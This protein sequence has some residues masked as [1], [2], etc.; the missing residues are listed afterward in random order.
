LTKRAGIPGFGIPGLETLFLSWNL[1]NH[2]N[3]V[4]ISAVWKDWSYIRLPYEGPR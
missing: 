2:R 1:G 4:D 3:D